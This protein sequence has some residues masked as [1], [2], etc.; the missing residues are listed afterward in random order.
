MS[1]LIFPCVLAN[2]QTPLWSTSDVR[3]VVTLVSHPSQFTWNQITADICIRLRLMKRSGPFTMK[4]K[5]MLMYTIE[6]INIIWTMAQDEVPKYRAN[7]KQNTNSENRCRIFLV[8]FLFSPHFP[9]KNSLLPLTRYFATCFAEQ[10]FLTQ[11]KTKN[12]F[13][14]L[15]FFL[16]LQFARS[17]TAILS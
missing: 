11:K 17:P 4:K 7:Y 13:T 12:T 2:T 6:S 10:T 1:P 14:V 9:S 5:I 16:L 15:F 3:S 8:Q